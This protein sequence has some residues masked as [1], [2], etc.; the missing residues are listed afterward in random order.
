MADHNVDQS[1][2]P[3]PVPAPPSPS[4]GPNDPDSGSEHT[5][6][7]MDLDGLDP[8]AFLVMDFPGAALRDLECVG[9]NWE[10]RKQLEVPT[11][12]YGPFSNESEY[13]L[14]KWAIES[15]QSLASINSLLRT[16]FVTEHPEKL[17]F[18]SAD[19]MRQ[20]IESDMLPTPPRWRSAQIVLSELL[21]QPQTLYYHD[22]NEAVDYLF[23][24]PTFAESMD[25]APCRIFEASGKRVFHKFYTGDGWWDAQTR[26]PPGTTV[27]PI[28]LASDKTTLTS[29]TGGKN[30]HP[31]YL[32]LGN[33]RKGVHASI[34]QKAY[35]LLAYIPILETIKQKVKNKSMKNKLPGILSKRLYHKSLD[36]ILSPLRHQEAH[37]P[38]I[39]IDSDG[40]QWRTWRILMGW[41]ANMEE[42]A[43]V[44]EMVSRR[45][46]T[47]IGSLDDTWAFANAA[48]KAGLCGVEVPCWAWMVEAPWNVDIA[49]VVSQDLLHWYHKAFRDYIKANVPKLTYDFKAA[50]DTY[51]RLGGRVSEETGKAIEGFQIPK[52]HVP[53]HFPDHVRWKGTL[54]GSTT[55]TS[56][57][58]HI[59]V[60]KD[61]WRATNHRD[62]HLLQ[63]L[64]WLDLRER[65]VAFGLY[66]EWRDGIDAREGEDEGEPINE[67]VVGKQ[68]RLQRTWQVPDPSKDNIDYK[69]AKCPH[70]PSKPLANVI[71]ANQLPSFLIDLQAY[72][73]QKGVPGIPNH[74]AYLD[75]WTHTHLLLL[76]P[77][78]FLKVEWRKVRANPTENTYD[79]ILINDG[80]VDVVGLSGYSVGEVRLIFRP[81]NPLPHSPHPSPTFLAYVYM[82]SPIPRHKDPATQFFKISK[83]YLGQT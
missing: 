74:F 2:P 61:A 58:L 47:D 45:S 16:K 5:N 55:E 37:Q 66:M 27:I 57:R 80:D 64:H 30:A 43:S 33:I 3:P 14:V 73:T 8:P 79:T 24:N 72:L 70:S 51:A 60:V 59:D 26:A 56:E 42:L 35:V 20:L 10:R 52:L 28:I 11:S 29:H 25:Y 81:S 36:K 18:T 39:A 13:E 34:N 71:S 6:N 12:R 32:T 41:I 21:D 62:S 1:R 38:P 44:H 50:R 23:G 17:G 77:N 15:G 9:T 78:D 49:K 67:V 48:K 54:D 83:D 63:M 31:L 68:T 76:I 65:M 7:E 82:F 46:N 19:R 69:L 40:Y 4:P 75:I 53:R 22:I